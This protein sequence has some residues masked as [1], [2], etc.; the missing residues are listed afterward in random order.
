MVCL[1]E[2]G[3]GGNYVRSLFIVIKFMGLEGAKRWERGDFK[4]I[5]L[6]VKS[7]REEPVLMEKLTPLDTIKGVLTL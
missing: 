5:I 2:L 4:F 3:V 6:G 1:V 7:Q